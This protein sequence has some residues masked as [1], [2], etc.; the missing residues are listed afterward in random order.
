MKTTGNQLLCMIAV[1]LLGL[2]TA[3]SEDQSKPVPANPAGPVP[4]EAHHEALEA[5][6]PLAKEGFRIRD[7]EWGTELAQGYPKFLQVTL[8]A[9]ERYLFAAATPRNGVK[10]KLSFFDAAGKEVKSGA[11]KGWDLADSGGTARAVAEIAPGKSGNYFV[12]VE[13]AESPRT[14]PCEI[15]LVYA[16]K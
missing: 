11:P 5:L 2:H 9:G 14:G 8:F 15:S 4:S 13:L 7:G 3:R 6:R 10:L 16:Y 12:G 1:A